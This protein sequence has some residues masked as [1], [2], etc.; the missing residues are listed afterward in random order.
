MENIFEKL[1]N[2][3]LNTNLRYIRVSYIAFFW[4]ALG[5][6]VFPMVN[7][8]LKSFETDSG[9]FYK[10]YID[11]FANPNNLRVVYNTLKM[12]IVTVAVCGF[13]GTSLALYIGFIEVRF[14]KLIHILLLSPM[15]VPGVV[16]VIAFIQLYGESG[17]ITKLIQAFWGLESIPYRFGGFWG[18]IFVHAYTQYVYFYLNV[19][20]SLKYLDYAAIEAARGLGASKFHIFRTVVWPFILPALLS[21]SIVTFISGIA[22]FSAPNLIGDRY[23]VLSTQIMISKSNNY[24]NI[25]SMQVVI[26]MGMGLAVMFLMRYFEQK[27]SQEASVRSVAIER[28]RLKNRVLSF[29]C[30]ALIFGLIVMI[31]LPV[32]TILLFSFANSS[33]IMMY[34]FP[35]EFGLLIS[36]PVAYMSAKRK[37]RVNVLLELLFMIPWAMPASTI[38][39]NLINSFNKKNIFVFNEIL[40][41]TYWILPLAYILTVIPLLIRTN[42]LA[43]GSFNMDLEYA[44]RGLGSGRL[45]SFFS[46][47]APVISPAIFSGAILVFIKC[48]GE[49]TMSALLYGV[50]NRPVSIAMVTAMQ[51]FDLGLCMAYGSL[52]ILMCIVAMIIVFRFEGYA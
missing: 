6:V 42:M 25:A 8:L 38:A 20:I 17:M 7:T 5:F 16:I 30:G 36:L 37:S 40:I 33:S 14:R 27:Y 26:L 13:I 2:S 45:K 19:S 4:I 11:Y 29:G 47:T 51:E 49:Y 34:I 32:F 22:S 10:N 15:M 21:S 3:K 46:V 28:V 52:V 48:V 31:I 24:L 12:G 23:K 1:K 41:G 43:F 35:R 18:I 50:S 39:I 9:V 44:S